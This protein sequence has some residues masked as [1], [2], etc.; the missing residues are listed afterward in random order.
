MKTAF[1]SL[2]M[3]AFALLA[4]AEPVMGQGNNRNRNRQ[5]QQQLP[6]DERLLAL[7]RNFVKDAEKL[8]IEYERDREYERAKAVYS[9]ILKL[10]PQYQTAR[11]KLA[12]LRDMENFSDKLEFNLRAEKS[13]D[14][15]DTKVILQPGKPINITVNGTWTANIHA[16]ITPEGIKIP[17]DF[18]E[19]PFGAVVGMIDTGD[20][21]DAVP[22]VVGAQHSFVADKPGR[23]FLRIW[24]LREWYGE[25]KT[26]NDGI[27]KVLIQGTFETSR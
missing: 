6:D 1:L 15:Q 24:D 7:H 9:E 17:D 23:L 21:K 2:T 27:L 26:D 12:A 18:K 5:Q 22:F 10:V 8:A 13:R 20:P 3:I 16:E 19:F 25:N 4:T 11:D 14:W